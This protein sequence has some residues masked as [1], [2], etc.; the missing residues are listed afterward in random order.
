M[1]NSSTFFSV[2]AM[3]HLDSVFSGFAY[4]LLQE[5]DDNSDSSSEN[6]DDA[7]EGNRD[8]ARSILR[9]KQKLDGYE[10]GEM[11][12]VS[13]QVSLVIKNRISTL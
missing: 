5:T 1:V 6:S 12:S 2:T 9:V 8:A 4:L 7:C 3:H 13:G 11:R 10:D